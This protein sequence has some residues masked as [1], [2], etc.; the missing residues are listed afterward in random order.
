MSVRDTDRAHVI[1]LDQEKFQRYAAIPGQFRGN[2]RDR[3]SLL[4]RRRTG[5]EQ[6]LRTGYFYKTDAAGAY[7]GQAVK[8]T[9]CRNVFATGL[10]SLKDGLSFQSADEFS[11]D[12]NR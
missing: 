10:C 2:R 12:P 1:A 3:H 9:K 8:I 7:C 11:I 6:A 5:R 4:N